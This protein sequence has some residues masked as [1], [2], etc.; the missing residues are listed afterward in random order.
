MCLRNNDGYFNVLFMLPWQE[1][2]PESVEPIEDTGAPLESLEELM[3]GDIIV[4]QRDD[5]DLDH[6]PLSTAR[7]YFQYA[8][9]SEFRLLV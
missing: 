6:Y 4:Y 1:V 3:D 5:L 2:R 8:C 7:D 9:T